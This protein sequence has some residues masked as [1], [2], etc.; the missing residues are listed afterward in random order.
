MTS[1]PKSLEDVFS[2]FDTDGNGFVTPVE[3]RNA[4]RKLGLG[5]T[6]RDIDAILAKIDSNADGRIDYCEFMNKFKTSALDE[7]M[8]QRTA[9]KMSKLKQLM[10]LHMTSANDAFKF[11]SYPHLH[12]L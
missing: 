1:A 5:L 3:F 8:K 2:E 6:S 4:I 12:S 9:S 7:R 10:S 11:V